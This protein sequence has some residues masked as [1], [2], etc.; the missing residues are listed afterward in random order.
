MGLLGVARAYTAVGVSLETFLLLDH[1]GP[2][3]TLWSG[4]CGDSMV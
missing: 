2:T 4:L 1:C 3:L